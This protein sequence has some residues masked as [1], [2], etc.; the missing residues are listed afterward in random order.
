MPLHQLKHIAGSWLRQLIKPAEVKPSAPL[1]ELPVLK[2][3][4]RPPMVIRVDTP[5]VDAETNKQ[6]L[7]YGWCRAFDNPMTREVMRLFDAATEEGT[8]WSVRTANIPLHGNFFIRCAQIEQVEGYELVGDLFICMVFPE[9]FFS[10]GHD[11]F[12]KVTGGPSVWFLELLQEI[13]LKLESRIVNIASGVD[14]SLSTTF[15]P[16][17]EDFSLTK[18]LE[19]HAAVVADEA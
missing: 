5:E 19:S 13:A 14:G 12:N 4:Q 9:D 11:G 6:F 8:D 3:I 17:H 15:L 10:D 7:G 16:W 1:D 18:I 2:Q